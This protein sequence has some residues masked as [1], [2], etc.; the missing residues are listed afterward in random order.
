VHAST[1]CQSTLLF[2]A[3]FESSSRLLP[4]LASSLAY[5]NYSHWRASHSDRDLPEVTPGVTLS[6]LYKAAEQEVRRV[7]SV[8]RGGHL[9]CIQLVAELTSMCWG[10]PPLWTPVALHAVT[11][12]A[13]VFQGFEV[14][15]MT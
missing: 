10:W 4:P 9:S 8:R 3:D 13:V 1:N 6:D 2:A 12:P 7:S 11:G 15:L 5:S 14:G